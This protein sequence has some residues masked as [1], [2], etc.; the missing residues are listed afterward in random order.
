VIQVDSSVWVDYFRGA[1]T[2]QA[3]T[4]KALLGHEPLAIGDLILLEVLQGFP[5]ERQF[6]EARRL[7]GSLDLVVLGGAGC[8]HRGGPELQEAPRAGLH[9]PQDHSHAIAT[10][11][12]MSG[13]KLL[14]DDRDFGAFEQH[15]RLRAVSCEGK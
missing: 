3:D 8:C 15:L 7:L 2:P 14:H 9:P 12:I 11:C 13:F 1:A 6:N 4:L 5:T 10:R